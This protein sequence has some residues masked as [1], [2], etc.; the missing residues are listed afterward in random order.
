M[1]SHVLIVGTAILILL[2]LFKLRDVTVVLTVK[3]IAEFTEN[4]FTAR[5]DSRY[6]F[7]RSRLRKLLDET[8]KNTLNVLQMS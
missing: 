6:M 3:E 1:P 7:N 4:T 8:G 5:T 2:S